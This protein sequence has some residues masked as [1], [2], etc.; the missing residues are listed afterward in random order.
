MQCARCK[1]RFCSIQCSKLHK[2]PSKCTGV[3][4]L[5]LYTINAPKTHAK[6]N[7]LDVVQGQAFGAAAFRIGKAQKCTE[8]IY[9]LR[10]R[11]GQEERPLGPGIK[12]DDLKHIDAQKS[13]LANPSCAVYWNEE[14][15]YSAILRYKLTL[16]R[17]T[18]MSWRIEWLYDEGEKIEKTA[19]R[20]WDDESIVELHN[21]AMR[22]AH[23][24]TKEPLKTL[25]SLRPSKKQS[26]PRNT[27]STAARS[28][29]TG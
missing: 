6:D 10:S 8:P 3:S 25:T 21:R 22:D 2:I 27:I 14:Y 1:Y 17:H 18:A 5:G 4:D 13:I 19:S 9:S 20:G 28:L 7:N 23:L 11:D 29:F 26:Q 16:K 15:V 12:A 24:T